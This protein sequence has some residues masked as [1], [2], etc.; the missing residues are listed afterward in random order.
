M[1]KMTDRIKPAH[2]DLYLSY[3]C[4]NNCLFCSASSLMR[5]FRRF[6]PG[7][8]EVSDYLVQKRRSGII[9]VNFTGGEPT[10]HPEF[11][12]IVAAAKRLGFKVSVNTNG[13]RFAEKEFTRETAP[14]ID[15]VSFS[16]HGASSRSHDHLM[17]KKGNFR[18]QCLGLKNLSAY[19]V[20][21]FSNTVVTRSNLGSLS[22]IVQF[23]INK[24]IQ[25][26]LISQVVPEGRGLE[27]YAGLTVRLREMKKIIPHLV[28]RA[29]RKKRVIRFFGFP[30]CIMEGHAVCSNDLY[31]DPRLYAERALIRGRPVLKEKK[32]LS[33]DYKRTKPGK[34]RSCIYVRTCGGIFREY[35]KKFGSEELEPV[36]ND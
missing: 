7:T 32:V 36:K 23:C 4:Q 2:I 30:M 34:C 31:F 33:P 6:P 26:I 3:R 20:R 17:G 9:S 14:F 35:Y 16:F 29:G 12:K 10:L 11:G 15:E 28:R 13:E 25:E 5:K 19:P 18:K 8:G 1:P 21:F 27:N 22:D 24:G